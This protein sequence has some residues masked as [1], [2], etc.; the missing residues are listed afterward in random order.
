MLKNKKGVELLGK[1][2]IEILIAILVVGLLIYAGVV[3][4]QIYFGNQ[5]DNQAK[6]QLE[7][8][9][10]AINELQTGEEQMVHLLAPGG[11][12]VVSFDKSNN[13]YK[14]F[15]KPDNLFSKNVVCVCKDKNCQY[16][17]ETE[18]PLKMGNEL[19]Y[20]VIPKDIKITKMEE[21]YGVEIVE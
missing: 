15:E 8:L 14:G 7:N 16:C 21:Y 6:S 5:R 1:N 20:V 17:K 2:L 19:V 4:F 3:L 18:L 13:F 12:H 11:W 10:N 9:H